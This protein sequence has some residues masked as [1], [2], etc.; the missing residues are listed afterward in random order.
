MIF[1]L[2]RYFVL[3]Y[4]VATLADVFPSKP[5]QLAK[6]NGP[7]LKPPLDFLMLP[8]AKGLEYIHS[9]QLIH[10]DI[11]PENVLLW[12]DPTGHNVTTKWADFGMCRQVNERGTYTMKSGI[13]GTMNWLAPELLQHLET[14]PTEPLRGTI[15]SDVFAEGLVFGYFLADGVHPF[16]F[17]NMEIPSNILKGNPVNLTKRKL[18]NRLSLIS[19]T[20]SL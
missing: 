9:M 8:L 15:K 1:C 19:L 3:E 14:K 5:G 13:K 18:S 11:K 12:I 17:G 2:Y 7:E 4:C 10:R 20:Q 16:G 6:Y